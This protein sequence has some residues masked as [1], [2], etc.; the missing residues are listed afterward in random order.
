MNERR[1]RATGAACSWQENRFRFRIRF[2]P[3]AKDCLQVCASV[4]LSLC[5]S[6]SLFGWLACC[7]LAR[8]QD[9]WLASNMAARL[10]G[11]SKRPLASTSKSTAKSVST[12]AHTDTVTHGQTNTCK[13]APN[14]R[15]KSSKILPRRT[16]QAV[17]FI[18]LIEYSIYDQQRGKKGASRLLLAP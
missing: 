3:L 16:E 5:L 14:H 6:V 8:W 11:A 10:A 13:Q 2:E 1:S 18:I 4:P 12:H 9:S 15:L 17:R 7:C